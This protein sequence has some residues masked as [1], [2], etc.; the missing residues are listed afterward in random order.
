MKTIL[1]KKISRKDFLILAGMVLLSIT[2]IKGILEIIDD[3]P[4]RKGKGTSFGQGAYG[5]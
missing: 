3:N 2:G 1:H 5:L 4:T